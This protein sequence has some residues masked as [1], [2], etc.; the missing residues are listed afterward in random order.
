M[1]YLSYVSLYNMFTS[2]LK[3]FFTLDFPARLYSLSKYSNN[4]G[5]G[6]KAR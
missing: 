3:G 2:Y 5:F 6:K 1:C 4:F